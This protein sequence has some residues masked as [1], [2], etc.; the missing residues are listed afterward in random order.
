MASDSHGDPDLADL[1]EKRPEDV[2]PVQHHYVPAP[3]DFS[4][5]IAVRT[6]LWVIVGA[7]I[8]GFAI[9]WVLT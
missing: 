1:L 2:Q 6:V 3:I 7:V 8:L 5:R 4:Y 9:W